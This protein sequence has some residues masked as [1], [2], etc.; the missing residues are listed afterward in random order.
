MI[1]D[2]LKEIGFSDKEAEIYLALIKVDSDTIL[3][4][5][6]KTKIGR[7]TI[8]P[9]MESLK[10][11]GF[12]EEI[13]IKGK[14]CYRAKTPDRIE[15]FLQEQKIKIDEQVNHAKD[16]IPQIK[17]IMRQDGD[18][19]VIEYHEGREAIVNSIKTRNFDPS[20]NDYFYTIYPRDDVEGLFTKKELQIARNV[21]I[22]S[23]IRSKS[24]YTYE[25]GE[26]SPDTTGDRIRIDSKDYPVK[27]DISVY[28]DT[29]HI[30]SLGEHLGSIYIKSKDVADTFR[31]L[32]KLAFKQVNKKNK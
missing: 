27:A 7:T 25:K 31:T 30:H 32:F 19:P 24:I 22:N 2:F 21:R 12:V 8:Y 14:I 28:G 13:K 16:I 20:I 18:I 17:G 10:E 9:I 3:D 29:I 11:K 4:L 1:Q 26:Y 23:K 5:S 15:S 6:R